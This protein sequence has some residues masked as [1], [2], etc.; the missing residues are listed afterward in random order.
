VSCYHGSVQSEEQD[1]GLCATCRFVRR[2]VSDRGS[3]FYFCERSL[4]DA[5]FAKYPRLP[6]RECAGYERGT[7][8]PVP[9]TPQDQKL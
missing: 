8:Y 9:S 1:V 4:T 7:Q 6:V 3:V 5:E 2:V